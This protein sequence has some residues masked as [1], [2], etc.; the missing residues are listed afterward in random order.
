MAVDTADMADM[1]DTDMV[2]MVDT[3]WDM[4]TQCTATATRCGGR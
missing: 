4:A 1:V 2:D 3:E